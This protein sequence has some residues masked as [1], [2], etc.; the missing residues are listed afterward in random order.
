[1]EGG[2]ISRPPVL[3]G[4]NY[5]YRKSRMV[6][7]LKSMDRKTWKAIINGWE[8]PFV[9]D[10]DGK[11]TTTLKREEEWSKDEDGLAL[12][13]SKALNALFTSVDKNMFRL[14]STCTVAKDAWEILKTTHEG[15]YKV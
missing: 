10:K 1:M 5:D 9:M 2:S 8:H 15:T 13:K 3:D 4:T 7:F 14:I 6:A 11:T 12:G